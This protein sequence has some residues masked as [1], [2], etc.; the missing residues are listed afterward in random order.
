MVSE[1]DYDSTIVA[2]SGGNIDAV[3]GARGAEVFEVGAG[4]TLASSYPPWVRATRT[5][6]SARAA[7]IAM[8]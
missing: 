2:G 4:A 3:P 7:S 5:A 8:A 1:I 6:A